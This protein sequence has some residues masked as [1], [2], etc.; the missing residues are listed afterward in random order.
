MLGIETPAQAWRHAAK[1]LR[2]TANHVKGDPSEFN[3]GMIAAARSAS[4]V[5]EAL[6]QATEEE[7]RE[8]A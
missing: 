4:Y 8:R 1:A 3:Q 7:E 2:K 6:A 5:F